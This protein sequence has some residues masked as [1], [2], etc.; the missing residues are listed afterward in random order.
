MTLLPG[1]PNVP[2][3]S[4]VVSGQALVEISASDFA[5]RANA[6]AWDC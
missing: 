5:A 2:V 6:I 4:V 1:G 3:H